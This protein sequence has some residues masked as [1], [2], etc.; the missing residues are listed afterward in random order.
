MAWTIMAL[1]FFG[2][3]IVEYFTKGRLEIQLLLLIAALLYL[4]LAKLEKK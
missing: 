1:F 3:S 2:A 4:V